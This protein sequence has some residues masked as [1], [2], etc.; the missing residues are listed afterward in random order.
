MKKIDKKEIIVSTAKSIFGAIPFGGTA[1][2]E[3]F[4]EYNGQ[5]K[6][7]RLNKFVEILAENFTQDSEINLENIKTENFNDLFESVLR[8]VVQTKSELKL[9]RFKDIL[10]KEL[11]QPSEHYELIDH[12]LDLISNLTEEEITIL[13]NHRHFT[14]EFE[15]EIDKLNSLKDKMNSLEQQ[16]K[17]ETIIINESKFQKP[18]D[19]T[20]VEFQKQKEYIDS[21]LKYKKAEFYGLTENNFMFYKQRLFSKGLLIDNRMNRIGNL[22][23]GHMGITEFGIEFIEFIKNNA[24]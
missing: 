17:K 11:S 20:K 5:I 4:F 3:L 8:R 18:F 14:I 22:P 15:E 24:E 12:Y 2:N 10:I 19:S 13:Y 16:M 21:F 6:Q 9:L 1:L 7:K 23:F